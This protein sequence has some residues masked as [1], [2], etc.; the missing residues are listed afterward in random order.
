[1]NAKT[2]PTPVDFEEVGDVLEGFEIADDQLARINARVERLLADDD[3]LR[4]VR[5]L[6]G[7]PQKDVA[8]ELGVTASAIAQLESRSLE[9]VQ[10]GTLRRY[11]A[12]LGLTMN[13]TVEPASR[14]GST[15]G[16]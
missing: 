1:V 6:M 4:E 13:V 14:A 15:S 8:S 2:L 5:N 7:V 11:F 10:L 3:V 12:A 9:A 16:G